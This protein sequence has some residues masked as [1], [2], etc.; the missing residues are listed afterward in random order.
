MV[1]VNKNIVIA[2]KE[3]TPS[4]DSGTFDF[5]VHDVNYT[6]NRL[7]YSDATN[8]DPA[9]PPASQTPTTKLPNISFT[10]NNSGSGE[11]SDYLG[12]NLLSFT[13]SISDINIQ[14]PSSAKFRKDISWKPKVSIKD[15]L[16]KLINNERKKYRK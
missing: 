8:P 1:K 9:N 15:S 3:N 13:E 11:I 5:Y 12:N 10:I 6:S 7:F 4:Y 14:I 2:V 16:K